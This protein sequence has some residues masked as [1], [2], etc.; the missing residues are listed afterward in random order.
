MRLLQKLLLILGII[1][2]IFLCVEIGISLAAAQHGSTPA[3]IKHITTGPYRFTV[4]LYNAPARA[5][6]ALPFA[7]TPEGITSGSWIYHVTSIPQGKT[8]MDGRIIMSGD[9]VATPIKDSIHSDPQRQGGIL[10]NAEI[11]VQG[12]WNLQ[13]VVNGPSGL[14]AFDIPVTATSLPAL[15]TWLG[16]IIGC[17]PVY[18]IIGFLLIQLAY[19]N[20][21]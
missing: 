11:S 19:K 17:I 20:P 15:P 12:Q 4:S 10:G 1:A 14:R 16:W 8:Q 9:R 5:G 18:G 7:I 21:K 2:L 6:L 13:V 3:Q